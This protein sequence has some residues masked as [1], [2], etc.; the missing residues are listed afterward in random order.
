MNRYSKTSKFINDD[1]LYKSVFSE[2]NVKQVNQYATIEFTYP[3]REALSELRLEPYI[4]KSGDRYWKLSEKYYSDPTYWWVIALINKKP[5]ESNI[6][7]GD[8][9]YVPLQLQ[10]LVIQ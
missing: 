6:N 7:V 5:I 4:W 10:I 2:R 8:V 9:I 1:E 3:S